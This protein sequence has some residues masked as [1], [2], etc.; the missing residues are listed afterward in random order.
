MLRRCILIFVLQFAF[1]GIH[2]QLFSS[3]L[4]K[5]LKAVDNNNFDKAAEI[6]KGILEKD[7]VDAAGA[8]YGMAEI[9]FSRNYTNY[10]VT[11]A[12]KYITKAQNAFSQQTKKQL[13]SLSKAGVDQQKISSLA[14][15]IDDELFSITVSKNTQQDY[16]E[17]IRLYPLNRNIDQAKELRAQL[18]FYDASTGNSE[19][20]I[21]KFIKSNPGGKDI[22]QAVKLRNLVAFQNAKA[23]NTVKA[24]EDFIAKYPDA[25]E[26]PDA[27]AALATLQFSEAKKAN[28]V[29][30]YDN[31]LAK[32]PESDEFTEATTLRNQLAYIQLLEQE[33]AKDNAVIQKGIEQAESQRFRINISIAL[34]IVT[35]LGAVL[36]Y[37]GYKIKQR[38][39]IEITLQKEIIEE[40]NKEI[41]DSINYAQRIQQSL[42]P[43]MDEIR[44]NLPESFVF[45]KPRN[46]VSG[47][48]YWFAEQNNRYYI[49][50]VD[51]TGHGVPGAMLSMIGFNF[52]NQL[53]SEMNM[54]DPG[55]ILDQL[56]SRISQTLN[57][58]GAVN[59]KEIRDGM[60][61][62][63]LCI[64]KT[65]NTFS[66][67]G[68]VRPL[69]YVDDE[70]IKTIKGGYYSIGGIKSLTDEPFV[71]TSVTPKGKASF[72]LFSDG[73]A[74]QF[75]GP[76]GKKFKT[77]KFQE[78]LLTLQDKNMHDQQKHIETVFME[79]MGGFEQVD[80]VCVIGIRVG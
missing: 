36:L 63:L 13:T 78:L 1:T 27:K 74:D 39:N 37:R 51:C 12:H 52:L 23:A 72:Y 33:K 47:D 66:F 80:D 2:A 57:K 58:D 29:E 18:S 30:A 69:Y 65:T 61:M 31:F 59:G 73:F 79:W 8:Y 68:A 44:K 64:D 46:I 24:L 75:G 38:A 28:T 49:A 67:S 55:K 60:D 54:T 3:D 11:T 71:T 70:G 76:K 9:Y 56:H 41:V 34:F 19:E 53:V 50:A 45:Y 42:L 43:S 10:S 77:K 5:G 14:Q 17:F 35:L 20:A 21:N 62:A 7:S 40:K 15:K 32:F 26:I 6:F 16:D 22:A 4:Q 48:F 25:S